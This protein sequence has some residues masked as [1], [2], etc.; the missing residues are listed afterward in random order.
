MHELHVRH[1]LTLY[2]NVKSIRI[3]LVWVVAMLSSSR[4]AY[5]SGSV[6]D[7]DSLLETRSSYS[8]KWFLNYWPTWTFPTFRLQATAEATYTS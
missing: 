7:Y 5:K 8:Q 4:S 1:I 3:D 6:G 2:T